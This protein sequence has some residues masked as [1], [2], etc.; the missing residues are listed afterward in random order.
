MTCIAAVPWT[1]LCLYWEMIE[2]ITNFSQQC[3]HSVELANV[4]ETLR[5]KLAGCIKCVVLTVLCYQ[6]E[7]TAQS[8]FVKV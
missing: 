1:E 6:K 2:K 5:L 4:C 3:G 7:T 8:H